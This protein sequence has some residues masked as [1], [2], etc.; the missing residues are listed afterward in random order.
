MPARDWL[1]PQWQLLRPYARYLYYMLFPE[2]RP[3][4]F[5]RPWTYPDS[6]LG[7]WAGCLPEGVKPVCYFL[8]MTDWHTRIQRSQQLAMA[9]A[10][11][12]GQAVYVNPHL[13]LEYLRPFSFDPPTRIARLVPGVF[14]LHIHLP[15]EHELQQR[16]LTP[17]ENSRLAH[18]LGR[19]IDAGQTR[20]AA[21]VVS[22]PAWLEMASAVRRKYGFPIVY[23]CHDWL[24]GFG[25]IAPALLAQESALFRL[26]DLVVFSAQV[27]QDRVLER[28]A[29]GHKSVL[30]RN[31][32]EPF[33]AP[34]QIPSMPGGRAPT[35]GYVG[36]LDHWFDVDA[37]AAVAREH[38]QW[39]IVL[40]GRVEDRRVLRLQECANVVIAGE[41]PYSA[42]AAQLLE[43]D[44]A[45]IPFLINDL[46]LATNPIKLYEYFSAGLPVISTRLPE[47]E[48]YRD[49]V[50]LADTPDQFSALASTAI[51]E[52]D[53]ALRERRIATARQETWTARAK[54]L[55][56]CIEEL[57]QR[58]RGN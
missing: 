40:A 51:R 49:L 4:Y 38:P 18:Q 43:W 29:I 56:E 33:D 15:R 36:S 48:A 22:S 14:E 10:A 1:I 45:M 6:R 3:D 52:N 37:V 16:A 50:Y 8:P 5:R 25:D 19:V 39:R 53:A 12:G 11:R 30:I 31:A 26:A 27:L 34:A 58:N 9:I 7:E 20:E 41:I 44:A 28:Q 42:V 24:P 13:G 21:L 46:T 23:D 17:A 35:I 2:R 32:V 57:Q 54:R 47:V 55:A